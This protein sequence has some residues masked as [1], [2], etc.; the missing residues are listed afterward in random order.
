M[1]ADRETN[2]EAAALLAAVCLLL[3]ETVK[4]THGD[5]VSLCG[6]GVCF[7]L[8]Q[9]MECFTIQMHLFHM[10]ILE[11]VHKNCLERGGPSKNIERLLDEPSV[12][13][14]GSR[15]IR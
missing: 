15:P 7:N 12:C 3:K 10:F 2:L 11:R 9:H 8:T 13:H 6:L 14:I 5:Q 1:Q 4:K